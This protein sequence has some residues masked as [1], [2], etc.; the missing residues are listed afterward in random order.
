LLPALA[1]SAPKTN[2]KINEEEALE[3]LKLR[4][5]SV[6]DERALDD[7]DL[8]ALIQ[9]HGAPTRLLDW[10]RS[11]LIALWFA[12]S[13]RVESPDGNDAAV[14]ACNTSKTDFVSGQ[15]RNSSSP[16]EIKQTK[17][18]EPPYFDRRLAAQQGLFSIHRYWEEGG[19]VVSL[20]GN[21]NFAS[22]IC[23]IVIP[24]HL[25]NPLVKELDC[26]GVNAATVFPDLAGLCRHLAIRHSL[27]PRVIQGTMGL[28]PLGTSPL[29]TIPFGMCASADRSNA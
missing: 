13:E 21:K 10:T 26:V 14:W 27:A 8:L 25:F 3:E 4:L 24:S 28:G 12:V 5:P 11:P 2:P 15:E 6:Y 1:R 18:F 17:F 7:W 22:K 16:F 29:G 20:E 23:K 19:R 9:H